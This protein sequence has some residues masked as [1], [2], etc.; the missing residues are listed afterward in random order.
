ML[1]RSKNKGLLAVAIIS[2]FLVQ[3]PAAHAENTIELKKTSDNSI[4]IELSNTDAIAGIQFSVNGRGGLR[5]GSY[6]GC[7]RSIASGIEMYQF[8]RNDSTL[9]VILL[10]PVRSSLPA[11]TGSIGSISIS[12]GNARYDRTVRVFFSNVVICNAAAQNLALNVK[13]LVW[14]T[15]P[16]PDGQSAQFAL[17]PNFPNPFNP[18]TTLSYRLD[19]AA[20]VRLAVY[21]I[22][23]RQVIL[24]VDALQPAGRCAVR[25]DA[26]G[27]A[28]PI[29]ASGIYFACLR[30]GD[31]LA[32]QKMLL[33]K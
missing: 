16:S 10:A 5:F 2:M 33:T 15:I 12:L 9:N 24:L 27:H 6:D 29:M 23:G 11:G 28:G 8:L 21:D 32:V 17:E 25:W 4:S 20:S 18:S 14:E 26:A 19:A 30:V 31:H 22:A 1:G 3:S 7:D 13:E